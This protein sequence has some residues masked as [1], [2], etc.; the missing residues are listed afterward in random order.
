MLGVINYSTS[1][2]LQPSNLL[3]HFQGELPGLALQVKTVVHLREDLNTQAVV[4]VHVEAKV[5]TTGLANW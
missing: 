4:G 2:K 1:K 3:E 5:L